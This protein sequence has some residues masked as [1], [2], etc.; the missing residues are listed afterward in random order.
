MNIFPWLAVWELVSLTISLPG[1]L[2]SIGDSLAALAFLI[3]SAIV[4]SFRFVFYYAIAVRW[5][6]SH[7]LA[8]L[9]AVAVI[10]YSKSVP[11]LL[12]GF[13]HFK[14]NKALYVVLEQG[15]A[16]GWWGQSSLSEV[17][18][19][20]PLSIVLEQSLSVLKRQ[21]A[22]SWR[23]Y[24]NDMFQLHDNFISQNFV[25]VSP[26]RIVQGL[27]IGS[28]LVCLG[29]PLLVCSIFASL[30]FG[31]SLCRIRQTLTWLKM[32]ALSC[33]SV[34]YSIRFESFIDL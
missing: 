15:L 21:H 16:M 34:Q 18:S 22:E 4:M 10:L 26:E 32:G 29:R 13:K 31:F 17:S 20:N 19:C 6:C 30:A 25:G 3:F 7:Y 9:S 14:W 27:R 12:P 23:A 33:V 28:Y 2:R 8:G 24:C 1:L 5:S 11:E